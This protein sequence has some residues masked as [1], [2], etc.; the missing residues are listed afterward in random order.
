MFAATKEAM[1]SGKDPQG[2]GIN[3]RITG[4]VSGQIAAGEH[5]SQSQ[6][7]GGRLAGLTEEDRKAL[8]DLLA[9]LRQQVAAEAPTDKAEPAL[10]KVSELEQAIT[11]EKPDVDTMRRVKDW[12]AKNVPQ[13]AGAVTGLVINPIVGKLVEAAG[14]AIAGEFKRRFGGSD[15]S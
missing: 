1:M 11:A 4:D 15:T 2:K 12:F 7:V 10:E 14:E 8:S 5:I 9:Q 6:S 3:I 13:L